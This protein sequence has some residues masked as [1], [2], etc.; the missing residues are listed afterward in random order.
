MVPLDEKEG[1]EMLRLKEA[2]FLPQRAFMKPFHD[3]L[4]V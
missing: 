2:A 3:L 1:R 4:V